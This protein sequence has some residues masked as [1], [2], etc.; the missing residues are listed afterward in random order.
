M[1]FVGICP[2][3]DTQLSRNLGVIGVGWMDH[4][5]L[6][7]YGMDEVMRAEAYKYRIS[8]VSLS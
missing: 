2:E 8:H 4:C 5:F 7:E 6:D 3:Y 1:V